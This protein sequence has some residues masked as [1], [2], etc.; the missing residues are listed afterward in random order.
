MKIDTQQIQE[1]RG[2]SGVGV[3]DCKRALEEAHGD[4]AKAR[5]ILGERAEKVAQ[6]KADREVAIG[7]VDSYIHGNGRIGVLIEVRC[8]TDFLSDSPQFRSLVKDLALQIASEAP[9]YISAG[10]VPPEV[11]QEAEKKAE[12][13]AVALG[14]PE[15]AVLQIKAGKVKKMLSRICLME[16][17]FIKDPE[18]TVGSLIQSFIARSGENIQVCQ[19]MRYEV[20]K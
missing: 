16:Q 12:E 2:L 11:I 6:K 7:V 5:V 1:L 4:F 10:D 20:P 8:E 15:K 17:A 18:V 3:M 19:F 14:K 9:R 13:N